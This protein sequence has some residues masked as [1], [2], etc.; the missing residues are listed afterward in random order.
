[1]RL[2]MFLSLILVVFGL[3]PA[4]KAG[5]Y[6]FGTIPVDGAVSGL[7]GST[8]GWGYTITNQSSNLW[9]V[10][11]ALNTGPFVSASPDLLFDFPVLDPGA[12]VTVFFDPSISAGLYDLV[13][14]TSAPT[15]FANVGEFTLS[16]DWW[17]GDPSAGGT[18]DS[19]APDSSQPYTASVVDS[20]EPGTL[21]LLVLGLILVRR[22]GGFAARPPV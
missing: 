10:T 12:T 6:V 1:M 2:Q 19:N 8:V 11:T 17:T 16:A 9:L 22:M 14:D 15:G 4:A 3:L 7:P 18:F 21:A 5:S 13:W 20:P